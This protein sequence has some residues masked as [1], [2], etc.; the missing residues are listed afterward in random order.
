MAFGNF[1]VLQNREVLE[2]QT[3]AK[4]GDYTP[5]AE[6]QCGLRLVG[7]IELGKHKGEYE[8]K[9]KVND[10]VRLIF[11]VHGKKWAPTK[12][13]SGEIVPVRMSVNL[14][15]SF[16]KRSSFYKLFLKMRNGREEITHMADMLGESFLG[17]IRHDKRESDGKIFASLKNDDGFTIRP[18]LIEIPV[19][20]KDEDEDSPTFGKMVPTGEVT[21]EVVKVNDPVG[22]AKLFLWDAADE[23]QWAS[24]YIP[25]EYDGKSKNTLQLEICKAVNFPGSLAEALATESG[26]LELARSGVQTADDGA[27]DDASDPDAATEKASKKGKAVKP[28]KTPPRPEKDDGEGATGGVDVS[29][30]D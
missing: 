21:Q 23:E 3:E 12:L 17:N 18:P 16:T 29:D 2:N 1:K 6:G 4:G 15:K 24:I 26:V 28:A 8:G 14:N 19:M 22:D 30:I 11:E 20:E 5:P 7:Y 25:G 27:E 10:R 13:D 9:P